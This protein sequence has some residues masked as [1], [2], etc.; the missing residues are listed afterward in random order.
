MKK[1]RVLT[2][3]KLKGQAAQDLGI[4]SRWIGI[5]RLNPHAGE[6]GLFRIEEIE[7]IIPAIDAAKSIRIDAVG[8]VTPDSLIAEAKGGHFDV[9]VAMYHDQGHIPRKTAGFELDEAT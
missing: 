6:G 9:V 7:E 4:A 1:E 2:V 3:I 8:P 5:A